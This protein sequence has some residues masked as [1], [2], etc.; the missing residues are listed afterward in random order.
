MTIIQDLALFVMALLFH[1]ASTCLAVDNILV[2]V[3]KQIRLFH[4]CISSKGLPKLSIPNFGITMILKWKLMHCLSHQSSMWIPIR[5]PKHYVTLAKYGVYKS[6]ARIV[7]CCHFCN[8]QEAYLFITEK[9][10]P[11]SVS[12]IR[13]IFLKRHSSMNTQPFNLDQKGQIWA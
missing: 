11:E 9:I 3:Q 2:E 8:R 7:D 10:T 6:D 13:S 12:E 4:T 1:S 5:I